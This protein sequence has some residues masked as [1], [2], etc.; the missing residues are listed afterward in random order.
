[1]LFALSSCRKSFGKHLRELH[2]SRLILDW[3]SSDLKG[4][5]RWLRTL[6]KKSGNK[7]KPHGQR[8]RGRW[9]RTGSIWGK[10]R[11]R[12]R[13]TS[14]WPVRLAIE[15]RKHGLPSTPRSG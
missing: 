14:M 11:R 2:C 10:P 6:F 5:P 12:I 13:T 9:R 4:V 7:R 1:M 15:Y 3:H 8:F